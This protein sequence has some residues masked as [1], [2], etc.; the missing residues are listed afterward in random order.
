MSNEASFAKTNKVQLLLSATLVVVLIALRVERDALQIAL[1]ILGS[2][3]GT[4]LLKLDYLIHAYFVEP[5]SDFS[6]TLLAFLKHFDLIG[7]LKYAYYNG[8]SVKEKTLNSV[9]FQVILIPLTVFVLSSTTSVFFKAL[10]LSTLLNSLYLLVEHFFNNDLNEWFWALK[11][12]PN[13]R[14]FYIYS[15]MLVLVFLFCLS[16]F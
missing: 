16:M 10:V 9:Q 3:F 12:K 6:K 15:G 14:T 2:F 4:Y 5:D 11:N 13:K 8:D 7:A 1:V